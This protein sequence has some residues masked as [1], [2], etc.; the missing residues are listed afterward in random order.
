LLAFLGA[1]D[2]AMACG[3]E[4]EASARVRVW[5]R[6]RRGGGDGEKGV[7]RVV[8]TTGRVAIFFL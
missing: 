7:L 6:R 5:R 4:E 8:K 3:E 2:D 1:G